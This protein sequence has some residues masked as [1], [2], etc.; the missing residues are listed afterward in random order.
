MT[1]KN[2]RGALKAKLTTFS[3]FM[4]SIQDKQKGKVDEV[5]VIQ[6]KE[7]LNKVYTIIDEFEEIQMNIESQSENIETEQ[8]E[9]QMFE[10][11]YYLEIAL[12]KKVIQN[13]ENNDSTECNTIASGHASNSVN[14]KLPTIKLPKFEG[15]YS[16]WLEFRDTYESLIHT[17]ASINEIQKFHYLRASLEGSAA[18]VIHSLEFTARNYAVAWEALLD[19]REWENYKS[20]KNVP[21]FSDL[22]TFLKARADLLET[23]NSNQT[24]KKQTKGNVKSFLVAE[25]KQTHV[26]CKICQKDHY[27]QNCTEFLKLSTNDKHAK[28][29]SLRLCLNCLRPGHVTKVCRGETCKKCNLKHHTLLHNDQQK[30]E[31]Q[32]VAS[33][34]S[35]V[36]LSSCVSD[37]YSYVLLSTVLVQ[38]RDHVKKWHTIRALL[39]S[40][41]QS[42]YVTRQL[43]DRLRIPTSKVN[44]SV[45]GLNQ[46]TTT[47]ESECD[48]EIQSHHNAFSTNVKCFVIPQ[49]SGLVPSLPLKVKDIDKDWY[50]VFP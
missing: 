19:L 13:Y 45:L 24:E 11:S 21:N 16:N 30:I 28:V 31:K 25:D 48:L 6:I 32:N 20:D 35:V 41:S 49:I 17:N 10:D 39:D 26:K 43:S 37:S 44:I 29:M 9:R 38:V 15:K 14:I 18:Q 27:I 12:A 50:L 3:K 42:S 2:K 7:R 36:V 34:S 1:D 23:L 22:K 4:K 40:G 33:T 5:D 47:I 46:T 8:G